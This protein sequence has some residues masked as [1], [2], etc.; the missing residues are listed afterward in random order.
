MC[1]GFGVFLFANEFVIRYVCLS[2]GGDDM[3]YMRVCVCVG[4]CV[5]VCVFARA[6]V[7]VCVSVCVLFLT[8]IPDYTT[9]TL[10]SCAVSRMQ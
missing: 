6:G 2:L 7:C 5:R 8:Y 1:I 3:Y 9:Q 10:P 4:V